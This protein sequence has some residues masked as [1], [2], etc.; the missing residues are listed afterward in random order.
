MA[1]DL[2]D[3]NDSNVQQP[4]TTQ[5][6]TIEG[7]ETTEGSETYSGPFGWFKRMM[8]NRNELKATT[9]RN[10]GIA[11]LISYGFFDFVTYSISFLLSLRAYVATGKEL[12]WKTLPQVCKQLFILS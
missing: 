1:N 5:S 2:N 11:A 7:S 12:T 8:A 3:E 6:E 9:L 4:L 10:Y